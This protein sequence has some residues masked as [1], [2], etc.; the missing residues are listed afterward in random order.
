MNTTSY[1]IQSLLKSEL[2]PGCL[3]TFAR[4]QI[5]QNVWRRKDGQWTIVPEPFIDD[6]NLK[7]RRQ[8]AEHLRQ[9]IA[10]GGVVFAALGGQGEIIAF[11]AVAGGFIGPEQKYADL[12]ELHTD[13]RYRRKGL[14]RALFLQCAAWAQAHGAQKL[15]ISAHSAEE[16]QAFYRSIGCI[17]A[18]WISKAHVQKEPYDCQME[19]ALLQD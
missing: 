6:W 16:S 3:D 18:L 13:N 14:G 15:Y 11:A 12:L 8:T 2:T 7:E 1:P 5:V 10:E 19:Y 17:D 4:R 9:C